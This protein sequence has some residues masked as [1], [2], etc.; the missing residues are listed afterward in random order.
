M[1]RIIMKTRIVSAGLTP[2]MTFVLCS[3]ALAALPQITTQPLN[4]TPELSAV[5]P[6]AGLPKPTSAVDLVISAFGFTSGGRITYTIQNRGREATTSPFVVDVY[7]DATRK[8]TIKHSTLP[9]WSEQ[10]VVSNLARAGTCATANLRLAVD[11]QQLV[12]EG[13]E[14][15]NSPQRSDTPV[16]PD[17][18]VKITKDSVN[19]NLEY[20][21]RVKVT[22][23][24]DASTERDFVVFLKG[25]AGTGL[26][27]RK[28]ERVGPLA[29]GESATFYG[30][31]H[32]AITGGSYDATADFFETIREK[33]EDNNRDSASMGGP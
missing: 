12:A 26:P 6:I 32:Y 18:V 3:A 7:V 33:R 28:E 14:T 10:K 13:D 21:P 5:T 31:K 22:N 30:R 9:S 27:D 1:A 20:R 15:N 17:L 11:S 24:G 8:D 23:V 29:P 25:V 19:N 16:C 4:T 2:I